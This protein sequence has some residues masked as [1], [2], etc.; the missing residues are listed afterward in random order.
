MA[1]MKG[2][3]LPHREPWGACPWGCRA[4]KGGGGVRKGAEEDREGAL[5]PNWGGGQKPESLTFFRSSVCVETW[6]GSLLLH[7]NVRTH[8]ISH[9]TL[10]C[11]TRHRHFSL[12]QEI[13]KQKWTR[14]W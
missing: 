2:D 13:S 6:E 3:L 10:N 4:W 14:S 11:S 7:K 8:F 1:L 9:A 12:L 5:K